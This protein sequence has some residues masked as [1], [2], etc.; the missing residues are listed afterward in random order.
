MPRLSPIVE[1]PPYAREALFSHW[2]GGPSHTKTFPS[3]RHLSHTIPFP[4]A[5]GDT[6]LNSKSPIPPHATLSNTQ[7][8]S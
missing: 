4:Y 3:Q 8:S 1:P 7:I 5:Q 6:V 2:A